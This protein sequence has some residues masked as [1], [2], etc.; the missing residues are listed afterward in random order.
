MHLAPPPPNGPVTRSRPIHAL[1][2]RNQ[3]FTGRTALLERVSTNMRRAGEGGAEEHGWVSLIGM[4][5]IGKTQ[6]ALEYAHRHADDYGLVWWVG[7]DQPAAV[8][9]SLTALASQLGLTAV[10][11]SL[12]IRALW[13]ELAARR[14]WLLV[15]DNLDDLG[16]MNDLLPPDGGR[17]LITGRDPRIGRIG[18]RVDITEF[19]RDESITLLSRRC[20]S[21]SPEDADRVAAAVGDLPL[22]VEQV[23][24]FLDE[25]GLETADYLTLLKSQPTASGLDDRTVSAHPGLVS[26]VVTS[27]DR[28]VTTAGP[29][30]AALLDRLAFL[31]PEPIPLGSDPTVGPP[32]FG[33][34]LGD[35]ATAA[36]A[37]RKIVTLGLARHADN[38]LQMH[39]LVH[40]LLR[41]RLPLA[42]HGVIHHA[43]EELLATITL[44]DPDTPESWPEYGLIVPHV[45]ELLSSAAALPGIQLD[46]EAFRALVLKVQ[47]Y[48]YF[49]GQSRS[50]VDI[51]RITRDSWTAR[52]GPDHPDTLHSGYNL[53]SNLFELGEYAQARDVDQEVWDRRRRVLGRDHQDTIRSAHQLAAD[54]CDLGDFAGARALDEEGWR[55]RRRLLGESHPDTLQSAHYL[56][57]D[58]YELGERERARDINAVWKRRRQVLGEDHPDTLHSAHHLAS[59]LCDL[60]ELEQALELQRW[61]LGQRRHRLG[62]DHP[63]T[64]RT[65]HFLAIT[66]HRMGEHPQAR[67]LN[68]DVWN[69]RRRLHGDDHPDTLRSAYSFA[70]DLCALEDYTRARELHRDT[71]MRRCHVL[72]ENHPDT[73]RSARALAA[74]PLPP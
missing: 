47:R 69:R 18:T 21:L 29:A 4:G 31:A 60:G 66:L 17:L 67:A 11:P 9:A 8:M 6:L 2:S 35:T 62:Q 27:R 28:L 12:L 55:H 23:G 59:D 3:A 26:V 41:A 19:E 20:P 51:C 32:R 65:E 13:V 36:L 10:Q 34:Q 64:L 45:R 7:A 61:V 14:D 58:L 72:G 73:Q 53:A 70:D 68:E 40:T 46:A 39:R 16:A 57:S 74:V 15:Y 71:W 5:G 44:G 52:L 56:G 33:L 48:L 24:C 37:V 22:S 25:T 63:D 43:A 42:E 54:L 38:A 30:A 49:S 50:A 1:P